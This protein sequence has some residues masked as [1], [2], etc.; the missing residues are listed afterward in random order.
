[1]RRSHRPVQKMEKSH[2][3]NG[4]RFGV[5]SLTRFV[6]LSQGGAQLDFVPRRHSQEDY[7][8]LGSTSGPAHR[9]KLDGAGPSGPRS[10]LLHFVACQPVPW[11]LQGRSRRRAKH[12][13]SVW[14]ELKNAAGWRQLP[15]FASG[16]AS[17]G[18]HGTDG[19]ASPPR[20]W[21]N[22][23]RARGRPSPKSSPPILWPVS[24][25]LR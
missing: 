21:E 13:G 15:R 3:P 4:Y 11:A 5:G 8:R 25:L 16:A 24:D 6:C 12:D 17:A 14:M 19:A 1:L 2:R 10:Q 20:G 9:A 23:L 22:V 7:R 18:V